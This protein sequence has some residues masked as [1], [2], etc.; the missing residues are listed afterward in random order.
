[1]FRIFEFT[2]SPLHS[3]M[4]Q[5]LV[6]WVVRSMAEE[7]KIAQ[8]ES[9]EETTNAP[10]KNKRFRKEKAWDNDSIDHWKIESFTPE[11]N[12]HSFLEESSFATLFPKYREKYIKEVWPHLKQLL[13]TKVSIA[14]ELDLLQGSM[15]VK[16]TRKTWDPF[17]LFRARDLLKL[18]ARG[19]PLQDAS[20]ILEDEIS[21]D[22]IKIGNILRN[23]ERFIK[24]RQRLIG[25]DGNTLK[26]IELLTN[27]YVLVQGNT[28]AVI[29]KPKGLKE[30]RRI[31][32]DCMNNVHP[33]YHIKELM[34]KREL[35]KDENL[36]NESWDR[37]LPKFRRHNQKMKNDAKEKRKKIKKEKKAYTP[38]PPQQLPRKIDLQMESGEYF[39]KPEEKESAKLKEKFAK[40]E[41]KRKE[42]VK[43]RAELFIAPDES[44]HKSSKKA[45]KDSK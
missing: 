10:S 11:D 30:V 41:E 20:R 14:V 26:A 36:K 29:G 23:K 2:S 37:F 15:A 9:L 40:Q 7:E 32:I 6:A 16:T 38:F 25:P 5:F 45:K 19:V 21:S 28:V 42:K 18:I 4:G 3:E 31:V 13:D 22:I 8:T 43:K 24:R 17:A 12:P 1:M 35:A 44:E 34:I 39:M 33:V 27:C